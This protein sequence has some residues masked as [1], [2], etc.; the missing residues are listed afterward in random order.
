M[1]KIGKLSLGVFCGAV[2][3]GS[4]FLG[5]RFFRPPPPPVV[6]PTPLAP[7]EPVEHARRDLQH[8]YEELKLTGIYFN[9]ESKAPGDWQLKELL[10]QS[11]A[12][13]NRARAEF[14]TGNYAHAG[15]GARAGVSA[16]NALRHLS[17][18]LTSSS[19]G[20]EELSPPPAEGERDRRAFDR[21]AEAR[22][23]LQTIDSYSP[24]IV[25]PDEQKLVTLARE[26]ATRAYHRA[27]DEISAEHFERGE[28]LAQAVRELSQI[29][30]YL[31]GNASE[32]TGNSSNESLKSPT[33]RTV[34]Q[35]AAQ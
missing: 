7:R 21:L 2:A 16:A 3:A 17:E 13:Y 23:V 34:S 28:E 30:E 31:A 8:A 9:G 11:R 22:R 35:G 5:W 12:L 15:A 32:R 19:G 10:K 33:P 1:S 20:K 18:A 24:M 29:A 25:D 4:L 14:D 27:T 6:R 26:I